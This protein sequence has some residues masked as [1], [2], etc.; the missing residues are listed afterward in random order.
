MR[1]FSTKSDFYLTHLG[2]H[3]GVMQYNGITGNITL[4]MVRCPLN[5][6]KVIK[7]RIIKISKELDEQVLVRLKRVLE[8]Y[9]IDYEVCKRVITQIDL[10]Y[11]LV[12]KKTPTQVSK[13]VRAYKLGLRDKLGDEE[14]MM[15]YLRQ[16]FMEIIYLY[17]LGM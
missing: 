14:Y 6:S 2:F 11:L 5:M 16:D 8:H 10:E 3:V 4:Y 13:A 7:D 12:G 9:K 1:T 15:S 17:Y